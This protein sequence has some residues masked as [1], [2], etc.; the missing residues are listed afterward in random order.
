MNVNR[1]IRALAAGVL[2]LTRRES[3]APYGGLF[4]WPPCLSLPEPL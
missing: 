1:A 4:L 3:A 2:L